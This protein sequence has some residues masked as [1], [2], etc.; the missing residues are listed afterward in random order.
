M[1]EKA[2][3]R[4][5]FR[6]PLITAPLHTDTCEGAEDTFYAERAL[7]MHHANAAS[8]CLPDAAQP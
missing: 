2:L 1:L 8:S 5:L 7:A 4:M 3:T 6:S